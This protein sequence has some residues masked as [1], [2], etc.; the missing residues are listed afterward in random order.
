MLL[1]VFL[2]N[3]CLDVCVCVCVYVCPGRSVTTTIKSGGMNVRVPILFG[4]AAGK[5]VALVVPVVLPP[6]PS[7][8][9]DLTLP[10]YPLPLPRPPRDSLPSNGA[11]LPV[12]GADT[13]PSTVPDLVD[14]TTPQPPT[15]HHHLPSP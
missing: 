3:P 7:D 6:T 15:P 4:A 9:S 1:P 10:K 2:V 14:T 11:T 8:A 5:S 13:Q 12:E